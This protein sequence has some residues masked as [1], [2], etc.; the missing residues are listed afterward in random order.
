MWVK[1]RRSVFLFVLFY[2]ILVIGIMFGICTDRLLLYP[3][4]KTIS[5]VG[6]TQRLLRLGDSVLEVWVR[7]SPSTKTKGAKVFVLEFVGNADRA[8]DG[9]RVLDEY[10]G[11]LAV[12]TW[13]VNYPGFGG[14]RGKA[15]LKAIP[16]AAL[17]A[18]DELAKVALNNPILIVG[19]SLGSTAALHVAANRNVAAL[20]LQNPPPLQDL[21]LRRHGWWNLWLLAL[22][23]SMH[24][25]DELN[26]LVNARKVKAP[27]VFVMAKKDMLVP[28]SYQ[29]RVWESYAGS[30][31]ALEL[32]NATHNSLL[33][34]S[35]K[36]N[37]KKMLLGL[38]KK[39]GVEF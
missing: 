4:N 22:P 9:G 3:S 19:T 17:L 30:K 39:I 5:T 11:T 13:I 24:V 35:E 1:L 8:E 20:V 7:R 2:A 33:S 32:P 18:Y 38:T 23:I 31:E 37:L 29:L 14:S 26:S 16:S 6:L 12:E 21:I 28:F 10:W 36:D 15:Q 27:A 34:S 25:P